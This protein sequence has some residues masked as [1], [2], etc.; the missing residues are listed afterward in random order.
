M[1][2]G[3]TP[4]EIALVQTCESCSLTMY[5]DPVGLP[6]IGWGHR[7][8]AHQPPI[9]QAQADAWLASDLETAAQEAVQASPSLA[10]ATPNRWAAITDFCFNAGPEAYATS[11]LKRYVDIGYWSGAAIANGQ[12]THGHVH[13]QLVVLPGLVKRRAVTSRWLL[14][15]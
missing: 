10:T 9:T 8:D 5:I 7:C 1:S 2:A 3:V 15:G 11:H 14:N 6:T 13:G 4:A 12:W